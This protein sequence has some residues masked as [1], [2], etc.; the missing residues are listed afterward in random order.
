MMLMMFCRFG[1][2]EG[3]SSISWLCGRKKWEES[4]KGEGIRRKE[5][6]GYVSDRTLGSFFPSLCTLSRQ[7]RCSSS[8]VSCPFVVLFVGGRMMLLTGAQPCRCLV[9]QNPDVAPTR[10]FH[11]RCWETDLL[12]PENM[13]TI[14]MLAD[15][16]TTDAIGMMPTWQGGRASRAKRIDVSAW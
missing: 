7:R 16:I 3:T 13:T 6:D 9:S 15:R 8:T 11:R 12:G 5:Y 14:A 1:W 2:S 4:G 10:R